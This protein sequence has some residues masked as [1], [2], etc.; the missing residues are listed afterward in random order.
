MLGNMNTIA[1]FECSGSL[2][3]GLCQTH[4]TQERI[5]ENVYEKK[6]VSGICSGKCQCGLSVFNPRCY[7]Q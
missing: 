6:I 5:E 7:Y 2:A 3:D 4:F 1:R